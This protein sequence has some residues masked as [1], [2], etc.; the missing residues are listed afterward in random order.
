MIQ[1]CSDYINKCCFLLVYIYKILLLLYYYKI[2][3]F[4]VFMF[5]L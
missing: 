2:D 5:Y 3:T 4:Y 1:K